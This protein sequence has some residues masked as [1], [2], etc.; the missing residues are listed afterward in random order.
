[1]PA[2]R[3]YFS[4]AINAL[5]SSLTRAKVDAWAARA[6]AV[7][8]DIAKGG[9]AIAGEAGAPFAKGGKAYRDISRAGRQL[10]GGGASSFAKS[11]GL[12]AGLGVAGQAASSEYSTGQRPSL[13][14]LAHAAMTG[15]IGGAGFRLARN[16]MAG[17]SLGVAGRRMWG[18]GGTAASAGAA[19]ARTGFAGMRA[20]AG[21]VN[22]NIA[23]RVMN[24]SARGG[25]ASGAFRAPGAPGNMG[26]KP[27]GMQDL[28]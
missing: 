4:R 11:A 7:A 17:R 2:A 28:F 18:M 22:N 13:G 21:R 5:Q 14:S 10:W 20:A 9:K 24:A 19:Q 8:G 23:Q 25:G 16:A 26:Y 12:G 1:M 15:A 27:M 6:A 3:P